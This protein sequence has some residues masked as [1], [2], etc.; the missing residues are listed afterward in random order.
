MPNSQLD[1]FTI[2]PAEVKAKF[3]AASYKRA[4]E[5]KKKE[6]DCSSD[7]ISIKTGECRPFKKEDFKLKK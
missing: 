6:R 7:F 5:R 3:Y 4:E 1:L 2:T